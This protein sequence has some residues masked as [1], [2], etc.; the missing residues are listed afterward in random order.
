[1]PYRL[2]QEVGFV[3]DGIL[4]ELRQGITRAEE[5]DLARASALITQKLEPVVRK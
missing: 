5:V 4:T 1:V 3:A 2:A